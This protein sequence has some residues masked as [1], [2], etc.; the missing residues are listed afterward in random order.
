[1]GACDCTLLL[2]CASFVC[3]WP[4]CCIG[5][6]VT[7]F[8]AL[9]LWCSNVLLNC[10]EGPALN[11]LGAVCARESTPFGGPV[12]LSLISRLCSVDDQERRW[13]AD[14]S[15]LF[16]WAIKLV[17]S[18]TSPSEVDAFRLFESP[19]GALQCRV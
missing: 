13:A 18:Y 11:S 6:A 2:C 7:C 8:A 16:L 14:D 15:V 17:L 4:W 1:M 9:C 19:V 12:P 10:C 5:A 3:A